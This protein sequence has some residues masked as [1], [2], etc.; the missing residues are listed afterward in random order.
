MLVILITFSFGAIVGS[1]INV[2]TYRLPLIIQ[3]NW[4]HHSSNFLKSQGITITDLGDKHE[5]ERFNLLW[6]PS[7]CP[8]CRHKIKPWENIPLLSYIFLKTKCSNCSRRI[9]YQYPLQSYWAGY[10]R[11]SLSITLAYLY[12]LLLSCF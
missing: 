12:Y 9:S 4:T 6:P 1:F 8:N 2:V 7:H 5:Q 11:C 3:K 10:W